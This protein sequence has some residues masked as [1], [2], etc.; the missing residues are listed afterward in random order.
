M[1]AAKY[2]SNDHGLNRSIMGGWL[3]ALVVAVALWGCAPQPAPSEERAAAFIA[4][5]TKGAV[6]QPATASKPEGAAADQLPARYQRPGYLLSSPAGASAGA[7]TDISIPVGARITPSGPKPLRMVMQELAKL[8]SMNISWANDVDKEALVHVTIMPEEDF[9][10]AIDNVLRQLDYFHAMEGNTIV[11]KHKETKKFHIA[12]PFTSST[13]STSVGGDVLGNKEGSNMTGTLNLASNDN[14]FDAWTNIAANLDK[15]MEVWSVPPPSAVSPT[16]VAAADQSAGATG[17]E[18]AASPAPAN[19]KGGGAPAP[20][21]TPAGATPTGKSG[22][23]GLGYYTIDRPIGLITVTAPRSVLAK[24]ESYLNNLKG[25]IYRQVS[26]EAK[27]IEVTLSSDNTTGLDWSALLNDS[28]GI[29]FNLDFQKVSSTPGQKFLTIDP[30]SFNLLIDAIK[31][32]GSVEVLSN[33]KISV[34]NGQPA[35]ISVGENVTY[36]KE[37]TSEHDTESNTTSYTI[38]PDSVMSGLGMGVIA[39]ILDDNEVILNLTPV[40]SALKEPIEYKVLGDNQVG[41]PRVNLR[42][43]TTMVRVKNGEML[44]VGGLIDSAA[45]YENNAVAGLG[46]VPG[47]AGK[48]FRTD[49]TVSKKKELI[50]LM[51]PQIISL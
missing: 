8:K 28:T 31:Q 49:G 11:I 4:E 17:Q 30:K 26:I 15:I 22:Q 2:L 35:M 46:E 51:R 19:T 18:G 41:L 14:K 24:I 36:V 3:Y 40:T 38:T 37:V 45:T 12:L 43:M 33:P 1:P 27:I 48:L 23:L 7:S 34:M 20:S 9:F 21:G 5:H 47:P 29:G 6:G 16:E 39:T 50:I 32:Q 44:V 13:Y 42:E 25:E 10:E